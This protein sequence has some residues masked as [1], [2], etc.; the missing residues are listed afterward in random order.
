[1]WNLDLIFFLVCD[2]NRKEP[3]GKEEYTLNECGGVNPRI[4]VT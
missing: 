3:V 1:M 4:H 2:E